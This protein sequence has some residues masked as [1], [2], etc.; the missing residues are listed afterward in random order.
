MEPENLRDESN[1]S[2]IIDVNENSMPGSPETL[3]MEGHLEESAEQQPSSNSTPQDPFIISLSTWQWIN[4][5]GVNLPAITRNQQEKYVAVHMVQLRLLSKFPSEIPNDIMQKYTMK[6]TKMTLA[7]AWKF[8]A[9]NTLLRKFDLGC[10]QLFDENDELVKLADVMMF[11]WNVKLVVMKRIRKQYETI[12]QTNEQNI[13][14]VSVLTNL[15]KTIDD[16]I[17]HIPLKIG[18]LA[19]NPEASPQ[20][21]SDKEVVSAAPKTTRSLPPSDPDP[22]ISSLSAWEWV[23]FDGSRLPAVKRNGERYVAVQMVQIKLLSK[24]PSNVPH[25]IIQK[26]T[27]RSHKMTMIEACQFNSIN[28]LLRKFDLGSHIY[29][30]SDDLVTLNDVQKFYWNVRLINLMRIEKLYGKLMELREH[31]T[32]I[33]LLATMSNLKNYIGNDVENVKAF[34][35]ELDTKYPKLD[36]LPTKNHGW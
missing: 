29:S 3:E 32:N 23:N 20:P 34:L 24:F 19:D 15:L 31:Q 10:Q 1:M 28:T 33:P 8:N 5:D 18:E 9:I 35:A 30:S 11:Y 17:Y 21:K 6:S 4:I 12:I 2:P 36:E 22:L 25:E 27:M 16:D 14:I 13:S 26:Y 7:E